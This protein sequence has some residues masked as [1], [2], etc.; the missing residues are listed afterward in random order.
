MG[1]QRLRC[2]ARAD[3]FHFCI[4]EED[5]VGT[6]VD[7][8]LGVLRC[9][10]AAMTRSS[11]RNGGCGKIGADLQPLQGGECRRGA[12]ITGNQNAADLPEN[13]QRHGDDAGN[14]TMRP[15][16]R[17]GAA[18]G[19]ARLQSFAPNIGNRLTRNGAGQDVIASR[20]AKIDCTGGA[21]AGG[22]CRGVCGGD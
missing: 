14:F 19:T 5:R 8:E 15:T 6:V 22:V 20:P 2:G 11:H 9:A 16:W 12:V 18:D 3:D 1:K 13:E 4:E 7:K 10:A 21:Y 17:H